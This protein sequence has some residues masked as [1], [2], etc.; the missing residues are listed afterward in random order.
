MQTLPI[1]VRKTIIDM[2][3][4]ANVRSYRQTHQQARNNT[5]AMVEDMVKEAHVQTIFARII[6]FLDLKMLV[7]IGLY[8][9]SLDP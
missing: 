3:P 5:R 9:R 4:K 2:L 7:H 6:D 1:Q 8:A